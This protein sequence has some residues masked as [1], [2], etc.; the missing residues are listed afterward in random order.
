[1]PSSAPA[2]AGHA[3]DRERF[4]RTAAAPAGRPVR[5]HLRRRGITAIIPQQRP[6]W[7]R[8]IYPLTTVVAAAGAVEKA[9]G[10]RPDLA[11]RVRV[12]RV[13]D[14]TALAA[15]T[16]AAAQG[17]AVAWVRNT[18]DDALNA[19]DQ[20][21]ALGLD[22]LLFH[23]R[24]AMGRRLK[25]ATNVLGRFGPKADIA[26]RPGILI[27]TQAIQQSLDFD[28]LVTNLAPA[29]LLMQEIGR[30]W[31]HPMHHPRRPIDGPRLPVVSP[32]PVDAPGTDWRPARCPCPCSR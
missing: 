25:V 16:E 9:L 2:R 13:S 12:E 22:P 29:D 20:P 31:R 8:A 23:A 27:A 11:R 7:Q 1:M 18:V 19:A 4:W 17:A 14:A 26:L 24:F 30:L 5:D 15:V 21:R 28:L 3:V 32:E 10:V 6:R